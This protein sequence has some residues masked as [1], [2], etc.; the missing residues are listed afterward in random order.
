MGQRGA[1]SNNQDKWEQEE[2]DKGGWFSSNL[3][4]STSACCPVPLTFP[5]YDKENR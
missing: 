5:L 4:I 1:D 3:I 2:V